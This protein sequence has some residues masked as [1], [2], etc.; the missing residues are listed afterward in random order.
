[1]TATENLSEGLEAVMGDMPAWGSEF[2]RTFANHAPMVLVA[3]DRIGGTPSQLRRF[4][5]HYRDT[6]QLLPFALPLKPLNR[7]SWKTAI[8]IREREPDLRIFFTGELARLGIHEALQLYLP[9]LADGIAA[10]AFHALMRTAYG[11]LRDDNT[12][13]AI[14]LA[15]WAATYL[16]LPAARGAHPI[17][18]DPAEVLVLTASLTPLHGMQLH[19]LLWQNMRDAS[20]VPEFAPVVDWLDIGPGT[21]QKMAA[22]AL[23]VF[24]AT[25]HFAALH[26]ITG[27]HWIRLLEPHC[28]EAAFHRMLRVFWQGIAAL[29]GELGFPEIPEASQLDRWRHIEVPDWPELHAIAARSY[30]EHDISLAFSASEEMKV[31][32]D[33]L[34]RVV[35]ARRLGLIGDYTK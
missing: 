35:V 29:M 27:L 4:F 20:S 7:D 15:Y 9:D 26:I 11:V 24:A 32:G 3:L 18:T 19:D 12:D 13:I 34:Y 22:T 23:S 5:N 1:M 21:L 25:Q 6:K 33:P 2:S 14:A 8:G 31:Y 10:S 30:D 17:T 16:P 28:D